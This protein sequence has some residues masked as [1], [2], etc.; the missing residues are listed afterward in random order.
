MLV[1]HLNNQVRAKPSVRFA[2][3]GRQFH[4]GQAVLPVPEL[5]RNQLLK[6]RMLGPTRH[7]NIAAIRERHQ[8]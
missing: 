3:A 4:V 5:R 1:N 2:L 7:G 8:L 6:E